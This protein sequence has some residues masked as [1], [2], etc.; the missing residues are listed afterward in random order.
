MISDMD[1]RLGKMEKQLQQQNDTNA[2]GKNN[3]FNFY[4]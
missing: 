2:K 4:S 3:L 1:R